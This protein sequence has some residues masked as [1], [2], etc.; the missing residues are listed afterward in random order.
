M[1]TE[2]LL[3]KDE[4]IIATL[5][6]GSLNMFE[7]AREE[8]LKTYPGMHFIHATF[9]ELLTGTIPLGHFDFCV[10]SFAIHHLE[11]KEKKNL[12]QLCLRT[13]ECRR[14]VCEH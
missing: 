6:D 12:F 10:S 9:Q 13:F 8:R 5:V 11:M 3:R 4:S 7:K 1:L 2:E 14:A